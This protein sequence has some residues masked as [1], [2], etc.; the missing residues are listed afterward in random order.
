[1]SIKSFIIHH[2][3]YK[4][5]GLSDARQEDHTQQHPRFDLPRNAVET[6]KSPP[7]INVATSLDCRGPSGR[8]AVWCGVEWFRLI[9]QSPNPRRPKIKSFG[10]NRW[11][12]KWF[13]VFCDFPCSRGFVS[14]LLAQNS[15]CVCY[16]NWIPSQSSPS[17]TPKLLIM[18]ILT[19]F[20]L[21]LFT[22]HLEPTDAPFSPFSNVTAAAGRHSNTGIH[23]TLSVCVRGRDQ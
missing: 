1:M 23:C 16:V 14:L 6:S 5:G 10:S 18:K 20:G 4:F 7:T 21:F 12:R 11:N 15:V 13:T 3:A 2:R 9:S 17:W 8:L 22:S 19:Q